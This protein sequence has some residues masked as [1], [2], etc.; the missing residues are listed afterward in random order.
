MVEFSL[1]KAFSKTVCIDFDGTICEWAFP[2]TGSPQEGVAEALK[3]LQDFGYYIIISSCRTNSKLNDS[4][5]KRNNHIETMKKYL[6]QYNIPYNEIDDGTQGKVVAEIY[7]DD[8]AIE[9]DPKKG[10]GWKF[11]VGAVKEKVA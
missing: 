3:T 9:F 2:N 6:K 10:K 11:V 4:A 7:I 8:R 1:P 5:K